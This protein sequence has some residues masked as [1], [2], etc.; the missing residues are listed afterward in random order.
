MFAHNVS[1][2]GVHP[3]YIVPHRGEW[4]RF[5]C[6][7]PVFEIHDEI[8]AW[9]PWELIPRHFS[10]VVPIG[11]KLAERLELLGGHGRV[12]VAAVRALN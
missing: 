6:E 11:V 2:T 9:I 5:G 10:L 8:E 1:N 12:D 4:A 7:L 3:G